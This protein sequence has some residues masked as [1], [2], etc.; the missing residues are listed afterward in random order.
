MTT[1]RS[2]R[3]TSGRWSIRLPELPCSPARRAQPPRAYGLEA[4]ETF[5][6]A[7]LVFGRCVTGSPG[8]EPTPRNMASCR[9]RGLLLL[10]ARIGTKHGSGLSALRWVVESFLAWFGQHRRLKLC[11]ESTGEHFQA[12]HDLAATL[13]CACALKWLGTVLKQFPRSSKSLK[14][15]LTKHSTNGFLSHELLSR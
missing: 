7:F 1:R 14:L 11:Y 12:F 9:D 13:I 8:V 5:S 3:W 6:A 10:L 15:I 4:A 2:P